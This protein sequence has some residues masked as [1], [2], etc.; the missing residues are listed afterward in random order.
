MMPYELI[1]AYTRYTTLQKLTFCL[2]KS[3]FSPQAISILYKI[4]RE[5]V[6]VERLYRQGGFMLASEKLDG[7]GWQDRECNQE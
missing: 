4:F 6:W 5:V 2:E 1:S 3:W 7:F